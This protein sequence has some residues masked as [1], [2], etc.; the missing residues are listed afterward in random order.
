LWNSRV[1]ES[2]A[3]HYPLEPWRCYFGYRLYPTLTTPLFVV[4]F[5]YDEFQ[6]YMD[7]MANQAFNEMERIRYVRSLSKQMISTLTNVSA[8]FIP[9]C[10]AHILLT[11][12]DWHKVSIQGITLPEAINCWEQT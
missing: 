10:M 1:P 6:L 3:K 12:L 9:S 4:Q 2:C 11:K 7:G 5:Q 8:V